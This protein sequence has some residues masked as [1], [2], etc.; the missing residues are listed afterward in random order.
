MTKLLLYVFLVCIILF[1][2]YI[3][4]LNEVETF[5]PFIPAINRRIRPHVRRVKKHGNN[6]LNTGYNKA[7][8]MVR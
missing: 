3:N 5:K 6:M 8:R 7:K 4:S 1:F 2:A